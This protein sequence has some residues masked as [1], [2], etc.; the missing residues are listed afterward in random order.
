MKMKMQMQCSFLVQP[1]LNV[2]LILV[3]LPTSFPAALYRMLFPLSPISRARLS[4]FRVPVPAADEPT[5][6]RRLPFG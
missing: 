6:S 3:Q 2:G 5:V 4:V 1:N